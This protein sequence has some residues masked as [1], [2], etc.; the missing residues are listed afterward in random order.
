MLKVLVKALLFLFKVV[1]SLSLL[2]LAVYKAMPF[3]PKVLVVIMVCDGLGFVFTMWIVTLNAYF[4]A[5][6]SI[7]SCLLIYNEAHRYNRTFRDTVRYIR[8]EERHRRNQF[9]RVGSRI[10]FANLINRT[11]LYYWSVVE[12]ITI[13]NRDFVSVIALMFFAMNVPINILWIMYLVCLSQSG[14]S[15]TTLIVTITLQ[16]MA[17]IIATIP[18]VAFASEIYSS[19]RYFNPIQQ[20]LY[21][22][23]LALK[24]RLLNLY[25]VIEN[26]NRVAF[27]LGPLAKI[28]RT[29][30]FEVNT[31]R[32]PLKTIFLTLSD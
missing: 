4:M 29:S 25:E 32:N 7:Y 31:Q 22:N 2:T 30:L 20:N 1:I 5:Y 9:I 23:H 10:R 26:K 8:F 15:N 11:V 16:T 19:T 13:V 28:T 27:T 18:I 6:V 12:I 14:V 21:K 24:I 3:Y 17:G